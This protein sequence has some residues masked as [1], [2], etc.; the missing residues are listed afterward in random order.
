MSTPR[1]LH[2]SHSSNPTLVNIFWSPPEEPNGKIT[3]YD[4]L[5]TDNNLL[6]DRKWNREKVFGRK[7]TIV[8]TNL[9]PSSKY[10]LKIKAIING[11]QLSP[12]SAVIEF[13]TKCSSSLSKPEI[14]QIVA[15][16]NSS[17][18]EITWRAPE[19][20]RGRIKKYE[21]YYTGNEI[22]Q[23]DKWKVNIIEKVQG[24]NDINY[25]KEI[26]ISIHDLLPNTNYKF[27]IKVKTSEDN[28]GLT[29]SLFEF[30]TGPLKREEN[31]DHDLDYEHYDDTASLYLTIICSLIIIALLYF[32][33]KDKQTNESLIMKRRLL[34]A[35]LLMI[36]RMFKEA[37]TE[38]EWIYSKFPS[39]ENKRLLE[40]AKM[41][42]EN[43]KIFKK[44]DYYKILGIK[45][46]AGIEEITKKYRE[47]ALKHHPD[48][49]PDASESKKKEHEKN[50]KD[51]NEAY[52][53][54]KDPTK[55]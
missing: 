26:H 34:R 37:V 31:I 16:K 41:K 43:L 7:T 27:M 52:N 18:V 9:I 53:V 55:R 39:E 50:M 35:K 19:K 15:G 10:F 48:K 20:P 6:S 25:V 23:N 21:I 33:M 14:V 40:D 1:N 13:K 22:S 29:T 12:P 54:L 32:C 3:G 28:I 5:Y 46:T 51:I 8:L 2:V 36:K 4:I 38:Y 24:F 44:K 45:R 47:L 42:L 30:L 49:Y 11:N 17:V